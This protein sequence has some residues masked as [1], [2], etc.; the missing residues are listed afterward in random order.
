MRITLG[1]R[2]ARISA[3][4]VA[5]F[6]TDC[7]AFPAKCQHYLL[8]SISLFTSRKLYSNS[9]HKHREQKH[10]GKVKNT[11]PRRRDQRKERK[12]R[13]GEERRDRHHAK[14]FLEREK[15]EVNAD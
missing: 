7:A 15:N 10:R 1:S 12:R 4:R 5:A 2:A 3:A 6:S 11:N 13:E 14:G 9:K 8:S